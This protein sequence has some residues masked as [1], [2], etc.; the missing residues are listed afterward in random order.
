M[1]DTRNMAMITLDCSPESPESKM[2]MAS[3]SEGVTG[4][5]LSKWGPKTFFFYF[6]L[7]RTFF[8][9]SEIILTTIENHFCKAILK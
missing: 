1:D 2:H 5:T 8:H 9:W 6:Q 7:W 4:L 3:R